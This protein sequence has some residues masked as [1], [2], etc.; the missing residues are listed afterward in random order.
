MRGKTTLRVTEAESFP[1]FASDT[2]ML[3]LLYVNHFV[4]IVPALIHTCAYVGLD[5]IVSRCRGITDRVIYQ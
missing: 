5:P 1:P 3:R 4:R 2:S